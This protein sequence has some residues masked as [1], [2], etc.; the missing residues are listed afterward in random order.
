MWTYD[1]YVVCSLLPATTPAPDPP[2]PRLSD[3]LTLKTKAQVL[4]A[5]LCQVEPSLDGWA[6]P[7]PQQ[8]VLY[9]HLTTLCSCVAV[10]TLYI[11]LYLV[12]HS[13]I[14]LYP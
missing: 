1:F 3:E 4:C 5:S 14:F 13:F 12:I 9:M 10:S 6:S 2:L 11:V 8:L 7:Q